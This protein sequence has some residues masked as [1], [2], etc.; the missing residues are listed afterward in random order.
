[1]ENVE[2][3]SGQEWISEF[4]KMICGQMYNASDPDLIRRRRRVR[5]LVQELNTLSLSAS[6]EPADDPAQEQAEGLAD[7]RKPLHPVHRMD[8]IIRSL[9]GKVGRHFQLEPPLHVDY[10]ENISVGN[11]CFINF[12]CVMLD[13]CPIVIGNNVMMGPNVSLYAAAHPTNARQ[14]R[15]SALEYGGPITIEDNV[16]LGGSVVVLP[17][18]T[19][20]RDSTIGAGSVV[21]RSIP[22]GVVAAGNPCRVIRTLTPEERSSIP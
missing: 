5:W 3:T 2:T 8:D 12:N 17:G 16:W 4:Q 1:M 18:V 11:D 14:R 22:P 10:G 13:T 21:T 20:G 7:E 6:A 9:F 19:I 15:E